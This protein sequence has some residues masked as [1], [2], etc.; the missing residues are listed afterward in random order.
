MKILTFL[1]GDT[2][3]FQFNPAQ[4]SR[5]QQNSLMDV[6]GVI[7]D[8]NVN[9]LV[10]TPVEFPDKLKVKLDNDIEMLLGWDVDKQSYAGLIKPEPDEQLGVGAMKI[11]GPDAGQKVESLID[12]KLEPDLSPVVVRVHAL[13]RAFVN[14][15][16][17]FNT[18]QR[19]ELWIEFCKI[20]FKELLENEVS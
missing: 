6:L 8:D 16:K 11:K 13:A 17:P 7:Q 4:L 15:I 5:T 2:M 10:V 9:E 18:N 12:E 20:L 14:L 19:L 1:K 3:D